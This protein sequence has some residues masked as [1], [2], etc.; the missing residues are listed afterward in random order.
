M[1]VAK[2][3]LAATNLPALSRLLDQAL[4]LDDGQLE[5]WLA[6]L[7]AADRHLAP[8][9]H[10]M[11]ASR[12]RIRT[13][14]LLT[15][16]PALP[17]LPGHEGAAAGEL[18][19]PYRLLHEL[20]RGGMGTVWLA[21]RA[22]GSFKRQVAIK[23]PRLVWDD[24]LAERMARERA[25]GALLEHPNIAR[26]Y[27]AGVDPQGRPFLALEYIDGLAIDAWCKQQSLPL[28]ERLQLMV[29]VARAVSYAHGR[30]VVHRDIKPSNVLVS[31]DG[32]THLLDFGIAKLLDEDSA[33]AADLTLERGRLMT[34]QYASPEQVGGQIITVAS[35]VY[36]LAALLYELLTGQCPY[37]LKRNTIGAMEEAILQGEPALASSRAPSPARARALRGELDAILAKALKRD[38]AQRYATAEALA[39]DIERY[40]RGDVVLARP[41]SLSYRAAK[42]VRRHAPLMAASAVVLLALLVGATVALVQARRA[43]VEAD[44]AR[45]VKEFVV[46][47]FNTKGGPDGSLGQMPGHALL[48][49]SAR[50][51]AT[52]FDGQ[53]MVQAEL[54]AV[55]SDMFFSIANNE[56]AVGYAEL[57][58]QALKRGSGDPQDI[59]RALLRVVDFL[60]PM[61]VNDVAEAKAREA[62]ALA[63]AGGNAALTARA[64]AWLAHALMYVN[65]DL[66][67]AKAEIDAAQAA[68]ARG[69]ASR[70]DRALVSF[71]RANWLAF[72]GKV[73]EAR[74]MYDETIAAAL[75]EEGPMSKL[76]LYARLEAAKT[77]IFDSQNEAGRTYLDAALQM[78]RSTGGVNDVNAA[79]WEFRGA[80]WLYVGDALPF[81][82]VSAT[83]ERNLASLL[84]QKWWS[85]DK[86][87]ATLKIQF[88][89]ALLRWGDI[90]RGRTLTLQ[91]PTSTADSTPQ[92]RWWK[93]RSDAGALMLSDRAEQAPALIRQMLVLQQ[94]WQGPNDIRK[95]YDRLVLSLVYARRHAEA[96]Q[97]LAEYRAL[98][99]V[100]A[101]ATLSLTSDEAP[102]T[103]RLLLALETGRYRD[104]I[105]MTA[106]LKPKPGIHT[107]ETAWLARAAALCASGQPAEADRL[108]AEWLPRLAHDR[109]EAN[110]HVA[111]WR[112]RMGLCALAG[113]HLQRARE[114]SALATA[115]L[116]RQPGVNGHFKA[117]VD[118][119]RRRLQR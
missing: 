24:R 82:E 115:A 51:I 33:G 14:D 76:A 8:L 27:D 16:L 62:L 80:S 67:A 9:L 101:D 56:Q 81:A 18:V 26:L 6:N 113:G 37:V 109:Y 106:G 44:R 48:E 17:A 46:D 110:P 74:V 57:Q 75:S 100:P 55:V 86:Y 47:I 40:L 43:N 70:I 94:S 11:L 29:Q 49:R 88:S 54:Y 103:S 112:A 96:E 90:E 84:A 64:H 61:D 25:I 68:L 89:Y 13:S 30:L 99:G 10:E 63:L 42:T 83:F 39:A 114:A 58:V 108:F 87:I 78:M 21:E 102:P 59:A 118:E 34:P 35:D 15:A 3:A 23:L 95:A 98:P 65:K 20:G 71:A 32:Q 5:A 116:V 92:A 36:S 105:E 45:L 41:D 79:L 93:L 77:L 31:A 107:D 72:S 1:T 117:P 119:L 53:P 7:D 52:K 104:L 85:P 28:R 38:P 73:N 97:A 19:G 2:L 111:Y 66:P 69:E 4:D 91:D 60:I 22:D 12:A 50:L